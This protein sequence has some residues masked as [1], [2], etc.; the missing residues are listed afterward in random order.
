MLI[1][2]MKRYVLDKMFTYYLKTE[3]FDNA[4]RLLLLGADPNLLLS[5]GSTPLLKMCMLSQDETK[6][7]QCY[8]MARLLLLHDAK[9]DVQIYGSS[10]LH[11]AAKYD[12]RALAELLIVHQA[13]L[14]KPDANGYTPLHT[15][16]EHNN[17]AIVSLLVENGADPTTVQDTTLRNPLHLACIYNN[18]EAAF[19]IA[20]NDKCM[21]ARDVDGMTPFL[22]ACQFNNWELMLLLLQIGCNYQL[23]DNYWYTGLHYAAASS[24]IAT[25]IVMDADK[26]E[27]ALLEECDILGHTALHIAAT[28]GHCATVYSLL[29]AGANPNAQDNHGKTPAHLAAEN[30]DYSTLIALQSNEADLHIKDINGYAALDF[31]IID[32]EII[33]AQEKELFRGY[34]MRLGEIVHLIGMHTFPDIY[35]DS[36]FLSGYQKALCAPLVDNILALTFSLSE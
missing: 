24:L 5:D 22:Y 2:F 34:A 1:R 23:C 14:N 8:E 16:V 25:S 10:P 36:A 4:Y 15:A 3:N 18:L 32:S 27:K 31:C 26:T 7:A 11:I 17:L 29:E 28:N 12:L 35:V 30:N 21:D 33:S 20:V 6:R 19:K 13:P 9:T